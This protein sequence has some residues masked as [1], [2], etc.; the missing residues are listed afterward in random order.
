METFQRDAPDPTAIMQALANVLGIVGIIG[1]ASGI[2]AVCVTPFCPV[3][4]LSGLWVNQIPLFFLTLGINSR[5]WKKSN[6]CKRRWT[7][8]LFIM[9]SSP[10]LPLPLLPSVHPSMSILIVELDKEMF[11]ISDGSEKRTKYARWPQFSLPSS[12]WPPPPFQEPYPV[13]P[14]PRSRNWRARRLCPF[15]SPHL[16]STL[17][18]PP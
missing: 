8:Y 12:K 16:T 2:A 11:F 7:P 3:P 15:E 10:L 6:T 13:C 1:L 9:E 4:W 17:I 14:I 5:S 18:T